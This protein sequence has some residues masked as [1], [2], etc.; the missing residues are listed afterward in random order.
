M[1]RKTLISKD[2]TLSKRKQCDLLSINRSSLY[3]KPKGESE[4]NLHLMQL[5]DKHHI[6]HPYKGVLQM[7]D[8]LKQEDR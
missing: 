1:I 8:Y 4:K 6:R 7:Q 3:V 5:I 2:K